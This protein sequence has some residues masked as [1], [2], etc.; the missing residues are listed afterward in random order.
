MRRTAGQSS[1]DSPSASSGGAE[2]KRSP[3]TGEARAR[4]PLYSRNAAV[5]SLSAVP[6]PVRRTM[7]PSS[8]QSSLLRMSIGPVEASGEGSFAGVSGLSGIGTEA[9]RF[10]VS[11]HDVG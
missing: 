9:S 8:N 2:A 7:L 11:V 10:I 5:G 6:S 3:N 4:T 1:K